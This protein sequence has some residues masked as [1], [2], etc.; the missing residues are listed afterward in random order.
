M[1]FFWKRKNW[2]NGNWRLETGALPVSKVLAPP[3]EQIVEVVAADGTIHEE[4]TG[5]TAPSGFDIRHESGLIAYYDSREGVWA[6]IWGTIPATV[7][8]ANGVARRDDLSGN[9]HHQIWDLPSGRPTLKESG[10]LRWIETAGQHR[11]DSLRVGGGFT[12]PFAMYSTVA[13]GTNTGAFGFNRV[14][15][16][17]GAN[18]YFE[19]N[20]GTVGKLGVS[21]R[22][23][24]NGIAVLTT[25]SANNVFDPSS[26]PVVVTGHFRAAS[27]TL[28]CFVNNT[29][30]SSA[31]STWTATT[32]GMNTIGGVMAAATVSEFRSY[33]LALFSGIPSSEASIR[34]HMG[35]LCGITI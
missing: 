2:G 29:S 23:L 1:A 28:E 25:T 7:D 19:F 32:G 14:V 30:V 20:A 16:D 24:T 27:D 15:R 8:T 34:T 12:M 18:D 35:T 33:G 4:T 13:R 6:D 21:I 17:T 10:G 9:G 3:L 22:D 5:D 26:S 11:L 31:T